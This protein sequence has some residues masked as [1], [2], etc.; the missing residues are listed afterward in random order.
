MLQL[1]AT[2]GYRSGSAETESLTVLG[3]GP[4]KKPSRLGPILLSTRLTSESAPASAD[5]LK[6][7]D[8]TTYEWHVADG[9]LLIGGQSAENTLGEHRV[10]RKS[11]LALRDRKSVV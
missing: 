1:A 2:Q 6:T 11:P 5:S 4:S 9:L 10:S 8:A 7:R 3:I